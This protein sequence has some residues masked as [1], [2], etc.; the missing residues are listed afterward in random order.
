MLSGLPLAPNEDR[1]VLAEALTP[2]SYATPQ[3]LLIRGRPDVARLQAAITH[4][5]ERHEEFRAGFERGLD[6]V[7]TK[8]IEAR[9]TARLKQFDYRGRPAADVDRLLHD[10]I[11]AKPDLTPFSLHHFILVRTGDDEY[12]FGINHHHAVIDGQSVWLFVEEMLEHYSGAADREPVAQFSAVYDHDWRNSD[13]YKAALV[14]WKALLAPVDE[15]A[16]LPDDRASDGAVTTQDTVLLALPPETVAAA[17]AAADACGVTPFTWFYAACCIALA[18]ATD[19]DLLL[20]TFQSNGRRGYPNSRGTIGAF[21]NALIMATRVDE[22]LSARAFALQIRAEIRAVTEQ[23]LC[24]YHHVIAATGVHP[25]F[26]INWFPKPPELS[27]PGLEIKVGGG[28]DRQSDYDLNLR[29]VRNGGRL[30][31]IVFYKPG[32]FSRSRIETLAATIAGLATG[33][34]RDVDAP[35]ASVASAALA[36]P[37]V[38]ADLAAPLPE[39]PQAGIADAFVA[40]AAAQPGLTAI[41]SATGT[42]TYAELAARSVGIAGLVAGH[43]RVAIVAER[44][45]ALVAAMLGCA[46]AGVTFVVLDSAYPAAR[47]ATLIGIARPGA[48]LADGGEEAFALARQLAADGRLPL[49][50]GRDGRPG[51]DAARVD[52]DAPAYFLFTSGSTGQPKCVAV[53]HRPL[54]HFAAWQ[55][56]SFGI[57]PGERVTMLSG[58]GHDPLLRDVFTTLSAGA[59]LLV[60]AQHDVFEPGA[61]RAWFAAARPSFAH[62]TPPLGRLLAAPTRGAPPL[63]GLKRIFWGG[64]LLPPALL[65]EV[66]AIAPGVRHTNFYGSTETPQAAGWFDWDGD[67]D[68]KNVPVGRGSDGFQLAIVDR[69]RRQKGVGEAGEIAVRSKLLC[70][71]YVE[72]GEPRAR[73]DGDADTYYTGDRGL[74]LP[75]GDI[76]VLGR[77]DDQLKIRGYRVD[78]AEVS[79]ALARHPRVSAAIA[80]PQGEGAER[81]IAAFVVSDLPA[82]D[83]RR[84]LLAWLAERLPPYMLPQTLRHVDALPLLPNGKVDRRALLALPD[85]PVA[86]P[87]GRASPEEHALIARWSE[88]LGRRDIG[89]DTSFVSLGGDSLSFVQVF[90]ATE[91]AV[92]VVPEGWQFMSIAE[93]T[94]A[95]RQA[96]RFTSVIDTSMLV[97]A[98]SIFFVVAGHFDLLDYAGGATSALFLVSGFLFGGLQLVDSFARKSAAPAMDLFVRVLAPVALFCLLL[99]VV[100]EVTG[101]D[102]RLTLLTFSLNFVDYAALDRATWGG[103]E[104]YLWYIHCALQ[105]FLLT[106]GAVWLAGRLTGWTIDRFRFCVALF[107]VAC[108]LRFLAP[109]LFIPD[110]LSEGPAILTRVTFLPTT[111]WA[112]LVLGMVV[113]TARSRNEKLLTLALVAAYA[114]ATQALFWTSGWVFL[115]AFGAMLLFVSRVPVPRPVAKLVFALSGASLFIY[116]T[117]FQWRVVF[118]QLGL[119]DWPALQVAGALAGGIVAW[120]VWQ[121]LW[122]RLVLRRRHGE[123]GAADATP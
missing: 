41:E 12:V 8:Y 72:A 30:E 44:S 49:L 109:A 107:G 104:F 95:K 19:D 80:L 84:L 102:E 105:L 36:P 24:P 110:Y 94:A 53:G 34:A 25:R 122:T 67:P 114:L 15:M 29:F 47:L 71:G 61:L 91:T 92:G 75:G 50:D 99:Y 78:L 11:F 119:P 45:P 106:A 89:R 32:R 57:G 90:L 65:A 93:L 63:T 23:E 37:G 60:P 18:R 5:F 9:S 100:K 97:R 70:M 21:S 26:G 83:E 59:T 115:L 51:A 85:E 96:A 123:Y 28:A 16:G 40:L 42:L 121:R 38:L 27:A 43:R 103:H 82:A 35:L 56:R 33:L 81:R 73:D 117:H 74:C 118:L 112:T 101:H 54:A 4:V 111:H 2:H 10:E 64:D 31:L 76:V 113:A 79:A 108:V 69:A 39:G 52:P 86:A 87:A 98:I 6:G 55:A 13:R 116:L 48:I 62:I 14:F 88:I 7:F 66:D 120:A 22:T 46:R 1:Y 3:R 68:W 20:T 17:E 58:L 77:T